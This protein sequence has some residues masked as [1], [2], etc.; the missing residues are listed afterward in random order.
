MPV[1]HVETCCLHPQG[2]LV[3]IYKTIVVSECTTLQS[4]HNKFFQ[5]EN[6]FSTYQLV[7]KIARELAY[8]KTAGKVQK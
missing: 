3:N 8:T 2:A 7:R 6:T 1:T 4:R 5:S